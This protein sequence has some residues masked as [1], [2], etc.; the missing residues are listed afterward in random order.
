MVN[1]MEFVPT[2][3]HAIWCPR[4]KENWNNKGPKWILYMIVILVLLTCLIIK[5]NGN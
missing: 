4:T 1:S 5:C 2:E 3:H